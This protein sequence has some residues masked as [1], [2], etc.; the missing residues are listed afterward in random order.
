MK[1]GFK[2]RNNHPGVHSS[3]SAQITLQFTSTTQRM[4]NPTNSDEIRVGSGVYL[5]S[6]SPTTLF[7]LQ[8]TSTTQRMQNPTNSDVLHV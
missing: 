3:C 1:I 5:I 4:Q 2:Q 7:T 6:T 8:F